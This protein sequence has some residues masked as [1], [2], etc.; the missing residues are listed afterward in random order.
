MGASLIKP[1]ELADKMADEIDEL[2]NA[3][4]SRS[5]AAVLMA[6]TNGTATPQ[7]EEAARQQA[8]AEARA[9]TAGW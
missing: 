4:P 2:A 7:Q 6:R 5:V 9:R 3:E 8:I 1:T